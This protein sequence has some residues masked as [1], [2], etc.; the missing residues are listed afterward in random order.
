[1]EENQQQTI[2]FTP[3]EMS[4]AALAEENERLQNELAYFRNRVVGLR[5]WVNQLQG[6]LLANAK[7]T[8]TGE[9]IHLVE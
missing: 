7:E 9:G 1:M 2:E 3:E 6:Q 8:E 4:T 5:A